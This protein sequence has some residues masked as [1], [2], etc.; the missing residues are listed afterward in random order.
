MIPKPDFITFTGADDWTDVDGMRA[1][2]QRY[3][4]EWGVLFSHSRQG[5]DPRYPREG[6]SR[7]CRSGL[8]LA[9]HLCGSYARLVMAGEEPS[10][11]YDNGF[12]DRI[13]VNH[14]APS[15]SALAAFQAGRGAQIIAQ[16][17]GEAFPA[18]TS[19]GW[20]FDASGG[21]GV[22]P[23]VWP[24]HPGR[25]VGYAGGIC[26][27]NVTQVI[28]DIGATAPY[29]LDMESGVRTDDRFD[30]GLCERVCQEVYG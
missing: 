5:I 23:S 7:I 24:P 29:W 11:P 18:E 21:R 1:L 10:F 28:A 30:L 4:I 25:L 2:A 3:P 16:C 15:V 27:D 12:F 14:P 9:A 17:R 22:A 6:L 20:L 13:Q 26:P 8:L 19:I